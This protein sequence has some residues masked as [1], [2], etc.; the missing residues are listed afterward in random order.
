MALASVLL[1]VLRDL[2]LAAGFLPPPPNP[3]TARVLL[4]PW[5]SPSPLPSLKKSR[6]DRCPRTLDGT[7]AAPLSCA[8][9]STFPAAATTPKGSRSEFSWQTRRTYH[10]RATTT[11]SCSSSSGGAGTGSAPASDERSSSPSAE[12]L[13]DAAGGGV[14]AGSA[15]SAVIA[16][17]DDSKEQEGGS[18]ESSSTSWR[19]AETI[20]VALGQGGGGKADAV[21]QVLGYQFEWEAGAPWAEFEDWLLQDTYSR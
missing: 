9:S 7:A 11:T 2:P 20:P 18:S 6:S 1:V 16:A 4:H 5:P 17:E 12:R 15:P 21:D 3:A 19:A 10:H 8:G 14:G 13:H